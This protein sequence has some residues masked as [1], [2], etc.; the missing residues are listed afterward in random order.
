MVTSTPIQG[1]PSQGFGRWHWRIMLGACLVMIGGSIVLSGMSFFHPYIIQE[2]FPGNN[3]VFLWYYTFTL[4]SIVLSMMLLGKGLYPRLGA[5]R[6]MYLGIGLVTLG[7]VLFSFGSQAW[8]F[9]LAGTVLGIGYGLS[10]QLV[11]IIWVNNW[12]VSGKGTAIGIVM[13]GTGVGGMLWSLLVPMISSGAG[14]RSAMLLV[15]VVVCVIPVLSTWLLMR[16]T[17]QELGL[18]PHGFDPSAASP[19]PASQPGLLYRQALRSPWLW[20][21]YAMIIVLGMVHAGSQVLAI[22]LQ[23]VSVYSD[24]GLPLKAQPADETAFFSML[25]ISWTLGL[26]AFKPLLGWLNDRIG[27]LATM[28]LSL[29]MQ[30]L[31]FL[32]LPHMVYGS[33]TMLMFVAMMFMAAGMSNGTVQPPLLVA[34]AVGQRDFGKIWSF[35]GTGYFIGMAVGTPIWGLVRDISGSFVP[36]FYASPVLLMLVAVLSWWGMK[37]GQASY[38]QQP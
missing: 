7:M 14:W 36:A 9:Y 11:P 34:G 15:A 13:G 5:K 38:R 6:M 10:F 21:V 24:P 1:S 35:F 26:L 12:F 30:A 20:L 31:T 18:L 32:Y 16:N 8:H 23:D 22:Y 29:G 2:L 17:P 19:D 27:M 37:Q 4:V 3:G 25:M 33:S 28:L